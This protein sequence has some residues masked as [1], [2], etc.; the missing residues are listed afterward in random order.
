MTGVFGAWHD[1]LGDDQN[2]RYGASSF[3]CDHNAVIVKTTNLERNHNLDENDSMY[4]S[5]ADA[6]E[7]RLAEERLW[8]EFISTPVEEP[9]VL[10]F[11]EDLAVNERCLDRFIRKM[12][13]LPEEER[14]IKF[15]LKSKRISDTIGTAYRMDQ[16]IELC[17]ENLHSLDI[18]NLRTQHAPGSEDETPNPPLYARQV[19][20]EIM[21]STIYLEYLFVLIIHKA[22]LTRPSSMRNR[23]AQCLTSELCQIECLQITDCNLQRLDALGPAIEDYEG[24]RKL[25]LRDCGLN[26]SE[27]QTL[28]DSIGKSKSLLTHLDLSYNGLE[29]SDLPRLSSMLTAQRNLLVLELW[30]N[31][32]FE[33]WSDE[34]SEYE[35]CNDDTGFLQVAISVHLSLQEL[36]LA[37]CEIDPVAFQSL[38]TA[39]TENTS[40]W[41]LNLCRS[42]DSV[43]IEQ[44]WVDCIPQMNGLRSLFGLESLTRKKRWE[45]LVAPALRRNLSLSQLVCMDANDGDDEDG[46]LVLFDTVTA[47]TLA[48][49]HCL[50]KI[51]G[52]NAKGEDPPLGVWPAMLEKLAHRGVD[53]SAL[54]VFLQTKSSKLEHTARSKSKKRSAM[55]LEEENRILHAKVKQL[56]REN[57]ALRLD[58]SVL[59][60]LQED[61]RRITATTAEAP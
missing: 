9:R 53:E 42:C 43:C 31:H 7:D 50:H 2:T 15:Q 44:D 5:S 6:D 47:R 17:K 8:E 45:S 61:T 51:A 23:L 14:P 39:L 24:L 60:N 59:E 4:D 56:E 36:D 54:F 1:T 37:N 35:N 46:D 20:S 55:G 58:H 18:Q 30:N 22:N 48:R 57:R 49:N 28:M 12:E 26:Q 32:L 10:S 3:R 19:Y 21:G 38:L 52:Y 25:R 40:L 33:K 16:L 27:L 11:H 41:K 13:R 34:E 29:N